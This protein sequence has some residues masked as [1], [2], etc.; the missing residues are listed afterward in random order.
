MSS[1]STEADDLALYTQSVDACRDST[2]IPNE[3]L[4]ALERYL[5]SANTSGQT[6]RAVACDIEEHNG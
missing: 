6:E 1:D 3:D 5:G 4:L 2:S